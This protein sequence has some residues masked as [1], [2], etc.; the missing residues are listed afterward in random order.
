MI[1]AVTYVTICN[2]KTSAQN[3]VHAWLTVELP[4]YV[5]AVSCRVESRLMFSFLI[6]VVSDALRVA[7]S[8]LPL[9]MMV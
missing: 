2:A 8:G 7:G 4:P 5:F 1:N 3:T 6:V 9:W